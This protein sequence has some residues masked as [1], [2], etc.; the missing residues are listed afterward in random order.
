[1]IRD[2]HALS[3]A[4]LSALPTIAEIR[5]KMAWMREF[6]PVLLEYVT[7][8]MDPARHFYHFENNTYKALTVQVLQEMLA[9]GGKPSLNQ[10]GMHNL[11]SLYE[12]YPDVPTLG[13]RFEANGHYTCTA[14]LRLISHRS[15]QPMTAGTGAC[16]THE[17]RY[18]YRW[19]FAKQVPAGVEKRELRQREQETRYGKQTLYRI[20]N[21]ELEDAYNAVVKKAVKRAKGAAVQA[22]PLVSEMFALVGDP[23]E[24]NI[25]DSPKERSV[26]LGELDMWLK[27]RPTKMRANILTALAIDGELASLPDDQ[28]AEVYQNWQA[29]LRVGV[30]WGSDTLVQDIRDAARSSARKATEELF[31]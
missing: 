9:K 23:D 12:V 2:E 25:H 24:E 31:T 15:G 19:V 16:S 4:P 29:A 22:L 5:Q 6:R 18:K 17:T 13:E 27:T 28:L 14:T 21:E 10:D 8:Q 26:Y 11:M 3:V 7:S 1:M 30:N 20:E